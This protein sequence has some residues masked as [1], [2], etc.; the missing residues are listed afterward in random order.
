[1]SDIQELFNLDA[2]YIIFQFLIIVIAAKE[3]LELLSYFRKKFGIKTNFDAEKEHLKN[4]IETLEKHD[5]WQYSEILKISAGIEDL[6]KL[7][8]EKNEKDKMQTVA[9]LR[10]QLYSM[11]T[12]FMRQKWIDQE[13]LKTFLELGEIYEQCDGNDVYHDKLK[14]EIMSLEIH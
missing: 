13:G 1:M 3:I 11:H 9:M 5:H 14:P 8:K 10:S 6:T 12:K 4:R 2:A 7:I